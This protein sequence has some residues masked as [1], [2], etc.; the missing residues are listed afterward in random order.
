MYNKRQIFEMKRLS[1]I[2]SEMLSSTYGY[3]MLSRQ[4]VGL[5]LSRTYYGI[6]SIR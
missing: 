3:A 1:L 2:M 6:S 5:H 4:G